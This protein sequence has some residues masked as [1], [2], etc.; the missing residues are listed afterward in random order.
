MASSSPK[1][2]THRVS[3]AQFFL[4]MLVSQAAVTLGLNTQYAGGAHLLGRFS[5]R[6]DELIQKLLRLKR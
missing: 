2:P 6:R 4:G 3:A 5:R 1:Q